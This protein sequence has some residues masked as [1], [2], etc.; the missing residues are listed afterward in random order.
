MSNARERRI[1]RFRVSTDITED[2][3]F[4]DILAKMGFVPLRVERH[5]YL[6][7]WDYTGTS[8]LF[9]LVEEGQA[10]LFYNIVINTG[11]DGEV[12]EVEAEATTDPRY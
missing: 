4:P 8:Q 9:G 2:G 5:P 3:N 6:P 10:C 1:G 12:A 7:A 11:D